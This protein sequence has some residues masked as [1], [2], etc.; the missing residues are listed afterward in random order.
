MPTELQIAEGFQTLFTTMSEFNGVDVVINDDAIY[1]GAIANAPYLNIMTADDFEYTP[2]SSR[3]VGTI[4]IPMML[5]EEFKTYKETYNNLR[6]TRQAVIDKVSAGVG[7]SANG[8]AG[9]MVQR[10]SSLTGL[11]AIT[12]TEG[13]ILPVFVYQVIGIEVELF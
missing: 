10:I 13:A 8:L 3:I 7:M 6:K 2:A 4:T 11:E 5:V 9:T 1:D 12:Y